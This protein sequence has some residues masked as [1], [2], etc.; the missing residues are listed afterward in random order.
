MLRPRRVEEGIARRNCARP[1]D[2]AQ[3]EFTIQTIN[4]RKDCDGL[5][6]ETSRL[7]AA[8]L[9]RRASIPTPR[10]LSAEPPFFRGATALFIKR[11]VG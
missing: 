10:E 6:I 3:E 5:S 1:L 4:V 7:T 8:N 11:G 2:K 9:V